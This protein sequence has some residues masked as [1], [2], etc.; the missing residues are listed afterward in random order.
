M[1]YAD[2]A[3]KNMSSLLER[4]KQIELRTSE[5]ERILEGQAPITRKDLDSA[6]NWA[7]IQGI[8][9]SMIATVLIVLLT[10]L[11]SRLRKKTGLQ[12]AEIER[13]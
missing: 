4:Q 13:G 11:S 2:E 9:T 6:T 5:L 10:K 1:I 12:P 3:S 8:G 7:W